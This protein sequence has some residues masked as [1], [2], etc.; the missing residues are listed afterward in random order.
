MVNCSLHVNLCYM[1]SF[2][3]Y[4]LTVNRWNDSSEINEKWKYLFVAAKVIHKINSSPKI[5]CKT[6]PIID[7]GTVCLLLAVSIGIIDSQQIYLGPPRRA[8]GQ[9]PLVRSWTWADR[10]W[11]NRL[12]APWVELRGA[13][14]TDELF[15]SWSD[16][17][18]KKGKLEQR[19]P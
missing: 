2:C 5:C 18:A 4:F 1:W 14:L 13:T 3:Q 7:P 16:T 6:I 17:Y 12:R 11:R 15:E 10:S 9:D 19:H 8:T